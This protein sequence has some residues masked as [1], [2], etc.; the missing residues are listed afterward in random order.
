MN[1]RVIL[2]SV[3]GALLTALGFGAGYVLGT[4]PPVATVLTGTFFSSA[5]QA[6]GHVDGWWYGIDGSVG[7]WE[8]AAGTWHLAGWPDCLNRVGYHTIR[9]GYVPVGLPSGASWRE[10]VWVS[11]GSA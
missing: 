9:F 2:V 6:S 1:K 10:V 3:V 11:C 4:R 7:E 8:D 5:R